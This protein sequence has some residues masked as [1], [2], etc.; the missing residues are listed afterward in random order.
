[1]HKSYDENVL[2]ARIDAVRPPALEQDG[3]KEANARADHFEGILLVTTNAGERIDDA[4]RR[5]LDVIV[6]FRAPEAPERLRILE[7][8]LPPGHL[9]DDGT[10]ETIAVRCELSGGQLRNAVLHAE[11]LALEAD[12]PVDAGRLEEGVRREYRKTGTMCPLPEGVGV[13]G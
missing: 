2:V 6:D 8:H 9:V 7:L 13:G 5:R 3:S 11:L 1:M 4:F 10:L 12:A